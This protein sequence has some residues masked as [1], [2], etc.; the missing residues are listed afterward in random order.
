MLVRETPHGFHRDS[1]ALW[2][3]KWKNIKSMNK[4]KHAASHATGKLAE[5][6]HALLTATADVTGEKV[7]EARKRLAAALEDVKDIAGQVRNKT[8]ECVKAADEAVH[9]HPYQA[10]VIGVG[11]GALIGFFVARP[12]SR[13]GD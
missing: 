11:G 12:G 1:G 5:D 2:R 4:H 8:V 13:N 10:M 6:A 7:A 3:R 9:E